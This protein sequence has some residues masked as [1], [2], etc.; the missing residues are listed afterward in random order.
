MNNQVI[1]K[2]KDVDVDGNFKG[3]SACRVHDTLKDYI[4]TNG[5][6]Y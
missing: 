2:M 5:T 4:N 6:L 1:K 3:Y